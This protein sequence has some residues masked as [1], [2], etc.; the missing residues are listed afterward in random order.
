M[1]ATPWVTITGGEKMKVTKI[2]KYNIVD[3]SAYTKFISINSIWAG[4]AIKKPS[5][6]MKT[7]CFLDMFT[8][9]NAKNVC[10]LS[11]LLMAFWNALCCWKIIHLIRYIF[12]AKS[13]SRVLACLMVSNIIMVLYK[14]HKRCFSKA[15]NS[16]PL[17][18]SNNGE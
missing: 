11:K 2:W 8:T 1:D 3:N 13:N 18:S 17:M 4:F 7:T 6:W 12:A 9:R 5:K 14:K 10:L 15:I 16:V